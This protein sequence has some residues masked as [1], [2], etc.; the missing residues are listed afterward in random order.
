[1]DQ[2]Q[3]SG[4]TVLV[5]GGTGNVGT[6][7][8]RELLL[9][10]ARV[11]VPS[12]SAGKLARLSGALDAPLGERLVGIEGNVTTPTGSARDHPAGAGL[13]SKQRSLRVER[14]REEGPEASG[15]ERDPSGCFDSILS[16]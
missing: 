16:W 1:M 13:Q 9:A 6:H 3:L 15:C 5:A 14:L 8:T 7:L 11:V 2:A 10:G 4:Y 12:R